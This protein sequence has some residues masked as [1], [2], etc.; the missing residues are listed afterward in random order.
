MTTDEVP[1]LRP[2]EQMPP[3]RSTADLRRHW[4]ALM[5]PLGFS[6]RLLWMIFLEA[7]GRATPVI[8]QVNEL[9]PYPDEPFL[10]SLMQILHRL[11]DHIGDGSAALLLSR[12]GPA[13]ATVSDRA[14]AESL[15][16]AAHEAGVPIWPVHLANDEEL[17]T[18][19]AEE[20]AAPAAA[21]A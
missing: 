18:W 19:A 1:P 14:W 17:V 12:P 4:R 21:T 7:D 9:D 6:E 20:S 3:I 5:G 13:G 15:S 8:S 2:P 10:T 16:Q 11:C